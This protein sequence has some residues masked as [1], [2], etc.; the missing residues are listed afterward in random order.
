LSDIAV[1]ID[2]NLREILSGRAQ[3]TWKPDGSPVTTSDYLV[4]KLVRDFVLSQLTDVDFVGEESFDPARPRG[5]RHLVLL[6]PVDGTENFCSGL[7]EWGVS[8]GIWQDRQHLGSLLMLPELGDRLM[9]GDRPPK[10]RSRILGL[11]SSFTEAIADEMRETRECRVTGCAVY[12]LYNVARGAFSRFS[13]P[14][15]A[16]AWDLLPG[17][18][19]ALEQGCEVRVDGSPFDGQFLEPD[20]RYRVDVRHRYDLHPGQGPLG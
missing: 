5:A 4:E 19:L 18:M 17:L 6:D 11:S 20:R 9:T 10:L 13:N 14:K 8:V 1:L 12:N 3:V 15:G 16:Y 2:Q 7:K